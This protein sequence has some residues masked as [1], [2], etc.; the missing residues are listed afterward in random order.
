M[1]RRIFSRSLFCSR[2]DTGNGPNEE[3]RMGSVNELYFQQSR[4]GWWPVVLERDRPLIDALA[5]GRYRLITNACR[6]IDWAYAAVSVGPLHTEI[7]RWHFPSGRWFRMPKTGNESDTNWC[8]RWRPLPRPPDDR[9][10]GVAQGPFRH[11]EVLAGEV[12]SNE[13][14][15]LSAAVILRTTRTN[16]IAIASD[17]V[18]SLIVISDNGCSKLGYLLSPPP[19]DSQKGSQGKTPP[20]YHIAYRQQAQ[21]LHFF[22]YNSEDQTLIWYR[23][24]KRGRRVYWL[25]GKEC[26]RIPDTA[27]FS[28]KVY[29]VR[30]GG[31][32]R[33]V[34]G[35][36]QDDICIEFDLEEHEWSILAVESTKSCEEGPVEYP[37]CLQTIRKS[38]SSRNSSTAFPIQLKYNIPFT[39]RSLCAHA[40]ARNTHPRYLNN[41]GQ[42][43]EALP[44]DR[45][46]LQAI[47]EVL[48]R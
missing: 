47:S 35:L 42:L 3:A 30:E 12:G 16:S 43:I 8:I 6:D 34:T 41:P 28:Q 46:V 40:I 4:I 2:R 33:L 29:D 22:C 36:S 1:L 21:E 27:L 32:F 17:C 14:G 15:A 39:L 19:D 18:Y 10:S 7:V 24:K 31:V 38:T 13:A 9:V 25:N 37:D 11:W 23:Y 44:Q 48:I 5:S 26:I 20:S 45:F